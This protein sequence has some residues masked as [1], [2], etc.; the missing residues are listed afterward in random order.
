MRLYLKGH[1]RRYAAEQMLATLFPGQRPEYPR[2]K[3][4][5]E[6]CEL[7][8]RR[9]EKYATCVCR[10]V[11]NGRE[12]LGRAAYKIG[13]GD[14]DRLENRVV[15]L[16]FYRAALRSGL[17][18]PDWGSLTG[19]R[20]GK[21][22]DAYLRDGLS[23]R[24]ALRRFQEEYYVSPE[25]ARLTL[26]ASHA[27]MDAK[28][29]LAPGDVCLYV[30]IPF[31]PTRCAYCSFVSQSV[32]KS[33]GLIPPYLDALY[34]E[35]AATGEAVKNAGL[36]PVSL[37]VGGGTPTTLTA[38]QLDALCGELER[39]FDLSD[40]REFTVEA[41]RPDT[42][43]ADKLRGLKTHGVTR[44]SVNPQSM[45]DAVLNAIGR[46]HGARDILDAVE[47]VRQAGGFQLN[48]DLI[49]G[50]PADDFEGF[51]RT[52]DAVLALAPENITV[53]TL[54]MKRGSTLMERR[55]ELPDGDC[56]R[57]MLDLAGERLRAAAYRPY[58]LYRQKLMSGGF[59]NVGWSARGKESLY[60][61]CIMEELCSV[62]AMGAGGSTKLVAG[63]RLKRAVS[64]K[65]PLEYIGALERIIEEK[66][67]IGEFNNGL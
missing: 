58:Y 60:N 62:I 46:K 24:A 44:V 64:P 42:I 7:T 36:R 15:K 4:E 43:T 65:Y 26:E 2:G 19:V 21:L 55:G 33:M 9:G 23:D 53:H 5:G 8:L 49:A 54:S 56:V 66:Q 20:P 16:A 12:T 47:L 14:E 57:K 59:E 38:L 3:P 31:C 37:Y 50:L 35:I 13:S 51:S 25:R 39:A 29:S 6:R 61:I 27:A 52:M 17:E 63:E 67:R 40:L 45:E 1:E 11:R 22:M 34:R 30:G 41:G 18:R 48:M 28:G 10:L 32:E